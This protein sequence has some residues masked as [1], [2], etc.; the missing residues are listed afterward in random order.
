[1]S[2]RYVYA[3]LI[4]NMIIGW[5]AIC[6]KHYNTDMLTSNT[7]IDTMAIKVNSKLS[8]D[9]THIHSEVRMKCWKC[10]LCGLRHLHRY[11]ACI[12]AI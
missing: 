3:Y 5:G 4:K 8:N 2:E 6:S 7:L 9:N 1:M 11:H 12:H 10:D